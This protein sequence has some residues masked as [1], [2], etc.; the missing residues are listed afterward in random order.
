MTSKTW[1]AACIALAGAGVPEAALAGDSGPGTFTVRNDTSR[2]MECAI[3]K[4]G[5]AVSDDVILTPG[6]TWTH[7]YPNAR[8][9]NFRCEDAAPV[10]YT[11][12]SGLVYRLAPNRYGLIVL[13]PQGAH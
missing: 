13:S 5:S 11:V 2:Q 4:S 7:Q 10:W 8:P 6:Q 9:R 1:F 12:H 3:R